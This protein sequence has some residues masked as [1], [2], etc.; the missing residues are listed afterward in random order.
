MRVSLN[1]YNKTN[2]KK[3]N[4]SYLI[5]FKQ[6]TP[7]HFY[8]RIPEYG[9]DLKWGNFCS[10]LANSSKN[11]VLNLSSAVRENLFEMA[12]KYQKYCKS[13]FF[14]DDFGIEK[15]KGDTDFSVRLENKYK[16]YFDICKE[17][18]EQCKQL[19]NREFNDYGKM[20]KCKSYQAQKQVDGKKM[21]LTQIAYVKKRFSDKLSFCIIHPPAEIHNILIDKSQK[22][23]NELKIYK[24][25]VKTEKVISK[26]YEKIGTIHWC[27]AQ[28]MPFMRGSATMADIYTKSLF[29]FT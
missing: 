26:I 29:E 21:V 11:K 3:E 24:N 8:I 9:K 25:T 12:E 2:Y 13:N 18:Y 22:I 5:S 1:N 17:K 14:E 28:G 15:K 16:A 7:E 6:V 4:P 20:I 19:Q 23:L 27:L 10:N